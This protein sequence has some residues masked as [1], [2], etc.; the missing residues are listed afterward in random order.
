MPHD[1]P[2]KVPV[3][4]QKTHMNLD[5]R[6]VFALT[7]RFGRALMCNVMLHGVEGLARIHVTYRGKRWVGLV[8][9][10]AAGSSNDDSTPLTFTMYVPGNKVLTSSGIRCSKGV[11]T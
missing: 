9:G 1:L 11:N 7:P 2:P 10:I 3:L 5:F 4:A 8:G 6:P